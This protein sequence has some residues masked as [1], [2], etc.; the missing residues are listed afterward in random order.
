[1]KMTKTYNDLLCKSSPIICVKVSNEHKCSRRGQNIIVKDDVLDLTAEMKTMTEEICLNDV[2]K[3][4]SVIALEVLR[5]IDAK[6]AG[7]YAMKE[8]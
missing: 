4:T 5:L 1:M 6:Y 3:K 2:T 7:K 8:F